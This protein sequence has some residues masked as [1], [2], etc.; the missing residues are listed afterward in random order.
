MKSMQQWTFRNLMRLSIALLALV[1]LMTNL[2]FIWL[3]GGYLGRIRA[4]ENGNILAVVKEV[5][6][7]GRLDVGE[8]MI[9]MRTTNQY[10]AQL[11]I[12]DASGSS[13]YES[14]RTMMGMMMGRRQSGTV[15]ALT[16]RSF[17]VQLAGGS[18]IKVEI[19]RR[20]GILAS[21][22]DRG[23]V[24]RM[25]LAYLIILAGALILVSIVSRRMAGRLSGP[26][27]G[28]RR[29]AD[30]IRRGDYRTDPMP[31]EAVPAEI[32]SLAR[33]IKDLAL[34]LE[35][36]EKIRKQMT[37][38]ISHEMR[39]P[40]AVIRSQIE[41]I[42][43]GVL[44]A[45]YERLARLNAEVMRLTKLMEDLNEL[46]VVENRL[47]AP[48]MEPIDLSAVVRDAA[49]NFRPILESKN[50]TLQTQIEDEV[51]TTG[52]RD[53]LMQVLNNLLSNAYKYTQEG[54]VSVS[55]EGRESDGFTLKIEDTG[56]GI[57]KADRPFIFERFYRADPSRSRET[58]GAGIGLAIV[59]E[60]CLVH[61]IGIEVGEGHEKGTL[62]TLTR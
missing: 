12:D 21:A 10:D 56:I 43:D 4:Q 13:L 16:Y 35:Q 23:F 50:L 37:S 39:S 32:D 46:A 28:I 62:F 27:V 44:E 24:L 59:K 5:F 53:R 41:A 22:V 33:T 55:L 1:F 2:G 15:Q 17:P 29:A 52:D 19:G 60:I 8:K 34:Q 9:L 54:S 57:A 58:G 14:T 36:Q 26:I 30:N 42:M 7:D 61:G 40:L 38:D 6:D 20:A 25:N 45:D 49:E 11:K 31:M 51:R 47:Y 18:E 48:K 3:F